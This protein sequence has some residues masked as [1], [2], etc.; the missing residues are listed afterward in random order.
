MSTTEEETTEGKKAP[1]DAPPSHLGWNSH[2]AVVSQN[3][4]QDVRNL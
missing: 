4:K 2:E 3:W 1:E